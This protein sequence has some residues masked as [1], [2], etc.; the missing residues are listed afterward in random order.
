MAENNRHNSDTGRDI[1]SKPPFCYAGDIYNEEHQFL[2]KLTDNAVTWFELP[3][4]SRQEAWYLFRQKGDIKR[5]F[6]LEYGEFVRRINQLIKEHK[7]LPDTTGKI[8][9]TIP[10]HYA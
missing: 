4:M 2:H 7:Q 3:T 10:S 1:V 6:A 9:E 5:T 8:R